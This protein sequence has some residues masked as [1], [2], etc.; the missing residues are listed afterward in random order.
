MPSGFF[1][2]S[3]TPEVVRVSPRSD[4]AQS[5]VIE[6]V[7]GDQSDRLRSVALA[8]KR[9]FAN[10]QPNLSGHVVVVDGAKLDIPHVR[11]RGPVQDREKLEIRVRER[12][13]DEFTNRG[14]SLADESAF[15]ELRDLRIVHPF[16]VAVRDIGDFEPPENNLFTGEP[17]FPVFTPLQDVLLRRG[18]AYTPWYNA[19]TMMAPVE[20]DR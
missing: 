6:R 16:D 8:P 11:F 17:R 4:L 12:A 18:S 20:G 1:E 13:F 2:R 10:H 19:E 3:D 7:L 9:P 5:E 15:E 14:V